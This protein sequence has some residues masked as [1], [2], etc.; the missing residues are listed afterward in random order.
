MYKNLSHL[1]A[2]VFFSFAFAYIPGGK[3]HAQ[4]LDNRV[5]VY[6]SFVSAVSNGEAYV[7]SGDFIAPAL[8]S[9]FDRNYGY[10]LA[11]TYKVKPWLAPGLH[12]SAVHSGDWQ[13]G[14]SEL[15]RD[16]AARFLF[17]GPSVRVYSPSTRLGLFNRLSVFAE[18][19]A[20][21]V[22][23]TVLL[24]HPIMSVGGGGNFEPLLEESG[25]YRGI[26]AGL[27]ARFDINHLVGIHLGY[28]WNNM[29]TKGVL[30]TDR[31]HAITQLE[32]GLHF[33]FMEN[34]RF[35]Y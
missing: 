20:G 14:S 21:A 1:L 30:F 12:L 33:R 10:R 23:S 16:A 35:Y 5:T 29:Q 8:F 32:F 7:Q 11:G 17:A 31:T 26:H 27:G 22:R 25:W 18:I 24:A 28:F 6:T 34:K 9:N 19:A 3:A 4:L 2:F 13:H 15:Y